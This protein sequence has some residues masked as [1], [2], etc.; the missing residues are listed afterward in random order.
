MILVGLVLPL[1][2]VIAIFLEWSFFLSRAE[3]VRIFHRLVGGFLG[4]L[5]GIHRITY[6]PP[7]ENTGKKI[8]VLSNHP[9]F[10]DFLTLLCFHYK[11][12]PRHD[13]LFIISSYY[14]KIPVFGKYFHNS[15]HIPIYK[16]MPDEELEKNKNYLKNYDR[17]CVVYLFPE[18]NLSSPKLIKKH[19]SRFPFSLEPRSKG[20][21]WF[22][23]TADQVIDLTLIYKGSPAHEEL[24]LLCGKY[25][26]SSLVIGKDATD[27]FH[28]Q[29]VQQ[30]LDQLWKNKNKLL[31]VFENEKQEAIYQYQSIP[32]LPLW[33]PFFLSLVSMVLLQHWI[34]KAWFLVFLFEKYYWKRF[35]KMEIQH[36]CLSI[37][38]YWIIHLFLF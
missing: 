20:L 30:T 37:L 27:M 12:F 17:P 5:L 10:T 3:K 19:G 15:P 2:Y 25:P 33:E 22:L 6:L 26:S 4:R 24:P 16:N 28:N 14:Q 13:P 9:G 35:E 8:I 7:L 23:P 31:E 11:H 1:C 18:G 36:I 21:S 32:F 29:T 34:V 38:A